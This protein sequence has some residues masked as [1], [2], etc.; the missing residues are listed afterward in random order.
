VS[1]HVQAV[2]ER[3]HEQVARQNGD[4]V[5]VNVLLQQR[6]RRGAS[7]VQHLNK[8]PR[9]NTKVLY[10]LSYEISHPAEAADDFLGHQLHVSRG[11]GHGCVRHHLGLE[12]AETGGHRPLDETVQHHV[13]Q[14]RHLR[15]NSL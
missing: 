15:T 1:G 11:E 10:F 3:Q 12:G 9:C 8:T 7:S 6:R 14:F 2:V 4:V 13:D 5:P